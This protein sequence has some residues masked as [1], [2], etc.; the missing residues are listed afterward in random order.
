[1]NTVYNRDS[2]PLLAS[3]VP[4]QKPV[5]GLWTSPVDS[6]DGWELW[7]KHND[8]RSERL[9]ESFIVT[10]RSDAKI[11]VIDSMRDLEDAHKKFGTV[12][13]SRTHQELFMTS[14]NFEN[15]AK[16]FDAIHLTEKGQIDTRF[17]RPFTLYGWDCESV[18]VLKRAAI[19]ID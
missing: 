6:T 9:E 3:F 4:S 8:Y 18:L 17:G 5:G 11:L 7:S 14:L 1:M 2:C 15:I 10:L 13:K 16:E 12:D 19:V